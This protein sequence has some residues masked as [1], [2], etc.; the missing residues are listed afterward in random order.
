M[1]LSESKLDLPST[2][3]SDAAAWSRSSDDTRALSLKETEPLSQSTTTDPLQNQTLSLNSSAGH[4][5]AR[6]L[7]EP[8]SYS[9]DL[10]AKLDAAL[11]QCAAVLKDK[12]AAL[13]REEAAL[14]REDAALKDK[15]AALKDKEAAEQRVRLNSGE[16]WAKAEELSSEKRSTVFSPTDLRAIS[17][18]IKCFKIRWPKAE[19]VALPSDKKVER[20]SHSEYFKAELFGNEPSRSTEICHVLPHS[21]NCHRKWNRPLWF[22]SGYPLDAFDTA[23][24]EQLLRLRMFKIGFY[25]NGEK[26]ESKMHH[27]GLTDCAENHFRMRGQHTMDKENAL[28]IVPLMSKEETL[29]WNGEAYDFIVI[30]KDPGVLETIGAL[31]NLGLKGD[32]H[33]ISS[34][35]AL[36]KSAFDSLSFFVALYVHCMKGTVLTE[37]EVKNSKKHFADL[38]EFIKRDDISV[39]KLPDQELLFRRGS[40]SKGVCPAPGETVAVDAIRGHPAPNPILLHGRNCNAWFSLLFRKRMQGHPALNGLDLM[41]VSTSTTDDDNC[42]LLPACSDLPG[43]SSCALCLSKYICQNLWL[44]PPLS[45]EEQD[46]VDRLRY[47]VHNADD[48]SVLSDIAGKWEKDG[49]MESSPQ[50]WQPTQV[51]KEPASPA[52]IKEKRAR[53]LNDSE[54]SVSS[55]EVLTPVRSEDIFPRVRSI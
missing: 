12:E 10:Q 53:R 55:P 39:P 13:Q 2:D 49:C 36:V 15:E 46:A 19:N 16:V 50:S 23:S 20:N 27:S 42:V 26:T 30:S 47:S 44:F 14:Q 37:P 17:R 38:M 40:F 3:G 1:T 7:T 43:F 31:K 45:D 33:S 32:D 24:E 52:K 28:F 48:L 41:K 11:Q 34:S 51:V 22:F 18:Q 25:E 5:A 6:A 21:E 54:G 35:N 8:D 29:A 9:N 4:S